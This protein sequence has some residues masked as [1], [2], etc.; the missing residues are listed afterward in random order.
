MP[1]TFDDDDVYAELG[2]ALDESED[3]QAPGTLNRV[4]YLS[5]APRFFAPISGKLAAA[6]LHRVKNARDADSDRKAV[7]LRPR[8]GPRAE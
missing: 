2:R 5:T 4:F 8:F 3:T 7:R 6:E 1:G